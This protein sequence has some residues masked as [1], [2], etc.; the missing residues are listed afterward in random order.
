MTGTVIMP[1][2]HT[3]FPVV[4]DVGDSSMASLSS[5]VQFLVTVT[6]STPSNLHTVPYA[7]FHLY[8]RKP[9][10]GCAVAIHIVFKEIKAEKRA[11]C[12]KIMIF[13]Q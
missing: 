11:I 9:F 13:K 8:F 7:T 2:S 4:R 1:S 5:I 12:T 10:I 3:E 6:L